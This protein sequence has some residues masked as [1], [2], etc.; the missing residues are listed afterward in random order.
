MVL[1]SADDATLCSDSFRTQMDYFLE[2]YAQREHRSKLA[3]EREILLEGV[4]KRMV[5]YNRE[6]EKTRRKSGHHC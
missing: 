1:R 5:K 4:I 3:I 2:Q 6:D